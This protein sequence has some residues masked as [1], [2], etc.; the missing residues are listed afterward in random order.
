LD[1]CEIIFG[2]QKNWMIISYIKFALQEWLWVTGGILMATY[3]IRTDTI[4]KIVTGDILN[5]PY[6]ASVASITLPKG[7]FKLECW[8]AQGGNYGGF[9]GYGG[10]TCGTLTLADNTTVFLYTGG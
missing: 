4:D 7:I 3:N 9:G 6:E 1:C 5:C 2:G 8:G 10:Y